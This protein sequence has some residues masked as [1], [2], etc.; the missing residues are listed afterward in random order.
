MT[1][2]RFGR[3]LKRD[4]TLFLECL[5]TL[6]TKED[7]RPFYSTAYGRTMQYKA[8]EIRMSYETIAHEFR[9]RFGLDIS[10]D[11]CQRW[12]RILQ[13]LGCIYVIT[14][15]KYGKKDTKG[16]ISLATVH[17]VAQSPAY[18][19]KYIMLNFDL[20]EDWYEHM[21]HEL[22][23]ELEQVNQAPK[24][25]EPDPEYIESLVNSEPPEFL[26]FEAETPIDFEEAPETLHSETSEEICGTVQGDIDLNIPIGYATEPQISGTTL[27]T[28]KPD[29]VPSPEADWEVLV[30]DGGVARD[31]EV[32]LLSELPRKPKGEFYATWIARRGE[33]YWAPWIVW[34]I[35]QSDGDLQKALVRTHQLVQKLLGYGAPESC[36]RVVFSTSKGFHVY[37]DSR[38]V[39]IKPSKNLHSILKEFCSRL[40]DCDRSVY[41]RNHVIGIPG[42][43]HRKTGWLYAHIPHELLDRAVKSESAWAEIRMR[44]SWQDDP[45]ESQP[46]LSGRLEGLYLDAVQKATPTVTGFIS[47]QRVDQIANKPLPEYYGVGEGERDRAVFKLANYY[48]RRGYAKDEAIALCLFANSRNRPPLPS[49]EVQQKV[50]RVFNQISTAR[51]N[52]V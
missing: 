45:R 41:D 17:Q 5:F 11:T 50:E 52:L 39:G 26:D 31:R 27:Q 15:A 9:Q 46:S 1:Q 43:K 42:S 12:C 32:R 16:F 2:A 34:D 22:D 3:A 8:G 19:N 7:Q 30:A 51:E 20:L 49:D 21:N 48:K 44:T 25:F 38:V 6:A 4:L 37:L 14:E 13:A 47:R 10:E 24:A 28:E 29:I 18:A 23:R 36:V 35:D 33:Q 40:A